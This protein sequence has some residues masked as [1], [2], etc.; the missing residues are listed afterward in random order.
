M[1]E[2][3]DGFTYMWINY[4][5]EAIKAE[6]GDM[7]NVKQKFLQRYFCKMIMKVF[8]KMLRLGRLI[9]QKILTPL[10]ENITG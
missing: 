7:E 4:K 6:N 5:M 1:G 10:S 9:R 8:Q 3:T 2:T